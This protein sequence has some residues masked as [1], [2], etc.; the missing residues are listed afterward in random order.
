MEQMVPVYIENNSGLIGHFRPQGRINGLKYV[1]CIAEKAPFCE[2]C[3][4]H[5]V[6]FSQITFDIRADMSFR[7]CVVAQSVDQAKL[8]PN[9]V[10]IS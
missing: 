5:H 10:E 2:A 3:K 7:P 4:V 1:V 9:F 8:L 6:V